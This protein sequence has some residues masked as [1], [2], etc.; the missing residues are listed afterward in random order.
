M[1]TVPLTQPLSVLGMRR[2]TL[3]RTTVR[4][5]AKEGDENAKETLDIEKGREEANEHDDDNEKMK[6]SVDDEKITETARDSDEARTASVV[7]PM[8][9][10]TID[11][12]TVTRP[13]TG[14]TVGS[15]LPCSR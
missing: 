13:T 2:Y 11:G 8:T 14:T 15:S 3:Q 1:V 5:G 12:G 9:G 4:S 7:R 10:T 6:E